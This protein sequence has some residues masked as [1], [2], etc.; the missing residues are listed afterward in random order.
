LAHNGQTKTQPDATMKIAPSLAELQRE[1]VILEL[2][3][4]DR[5]YLNAYVPKLTSENGIAAY[6]RGFLYFED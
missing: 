3:C 5:M 2:Q 4:I 6:F 1:N